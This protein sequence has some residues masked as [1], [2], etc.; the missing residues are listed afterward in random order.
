MKENNFG[1]FFTAKFIFIVPKKK[2]GNLCSQMYHALYIYSKDST[3][4]SPVLQT[5][6]QKP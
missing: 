5:F 2:N 4:R 6:G 1:C 3:K